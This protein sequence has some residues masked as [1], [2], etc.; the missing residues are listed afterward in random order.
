VYVSVGFEALFE[1]VRYA[2]DF[3]VLQKAAGAFPRRDL[4]LCAA[5]PFLYRFGNS[6]LPFL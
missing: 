3:I 4:W 5:S 2:D 6:R 1:M